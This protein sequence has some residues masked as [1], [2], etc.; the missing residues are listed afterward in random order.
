MIEEGYYIFAVRGDFPQSKA[1][2][3]AFITPV[4]GTGKI[5]GSLNEGEVGF[6]E[7]GRR[8]G[9][10]EDDPEISRALKESIEESDKGDRT[11]KRV[12]EESEEE[13]LK[14]VLAESAGEDQDLKRA[15][16]ESLKG[17]SG[18]GVGKRAADS[19]LDRV[20]LARLARF[21]K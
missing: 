20:R 10:Y 7:S 16:Q 19:D 15:I 13:Q 1:D 2:A 6:K 4:P 3:E 18:D 17:T 12:L 14:R 5:W 8:L 11:L 9:G 21:N